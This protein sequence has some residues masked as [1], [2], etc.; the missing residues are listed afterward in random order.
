MGVYDVQGL[1]FWK[2]EGA[3]IALARDYPDLRP[4][5][6]ELDRV[7]RLYGERLQLNRTGDDEKIVTGTAGTSDN[8]VKWNADGDAVDSLGI[9]SGGERSADPADP[10]EGRY[11][12]WMSDGT[13]TGDDGDVLLKVTAGGSTK[14]VIL[15]D[16]SRIP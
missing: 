2:G 3:I 6:S 11:V 4:V 12:I 10:A 8:L 13:G 9:L 5:L 16:F 14:T 7:L 1:E 15:M